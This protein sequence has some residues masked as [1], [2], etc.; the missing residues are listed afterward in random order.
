[1][2]LAALAAFV[3]TIEGLGLFAGIDA[4]FYDHFFR[5]RGSRQ[6]SDRVVVV[7]VDADSLA[8]FGRW[9]LPRHLY[10]ALLDRLEHATVVGFDLL[11]TEPSADDRQLAAASRNHGSVILAGHLERGGGLV[12]PL[13][14]FSPREVA[15]VHVE[16][17]VDHVVRELFHS[18]YRKGVLIPSLSSA[19]YETDRGKPIPRAAFSGDR[20]GLV[21]QDHHRINYYGPAGTFTTVSLVDVLEGRRSPDFF[22]GRLVLVGVTAPGIVDQVA[23]PFS[24]LRTRMPGVELHATALNNLLDAS[25]LR[26]MGQWFETTSLL[27]FS[28]LFARLFLAIRE[29]Q[30]LLAW[31]ASLVM[32]PS[33]SLLLF[34][35]GTWLPPTAFMVS[36][37]VMFAVVYLRRLNRA[38]R[39]LDREYDAMV[40]LLGR[41]IGGEMGEE[42]E[43][44]GLLSMLSEQGINQKIRRQSIMTARLVAMHKKLEAVLET[45]RETLDNQIRFVEMLSHE[46]RT[47]LA[48]I[49]ANLDILELRDEEA[50]KR[51]TAYY[52]KMKRAVSRLTEI[53]DI[54]LSAERMDGTANRMQQR[55]LELTGFVRMLFEESCALWTE[56]T[57]HLELPE[58]DEVVIFADAGLFKT[59]L[60]NLIDNAIKHSPPEEAVSIA[61]QVGTGAAIVSVCNRRPFIPAEELERVFDKYYRGRNSANSQGAGLG[62]YLVRKIVEQQGGTVELSS[63]EEAGTRATVTMPLLRTDGEATAAGRHAS[64]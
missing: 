56:R 62:L 34:V 63:S 54:S 53:M 9:P 40:T 25:A 16:P 32:L 23:T 35:G 12:E 60:L 61:L 55:R 30:A 42:T 45:E 29:Q 26:E 28:L 22:R 48:I 58:G 50:P 44:G 3:S 49:R 27:V 36:G 31:C 15:H 18:I 52:D 6:T 57:L 8:A 20:N 46:Y 59:V 37:S 24:Q 33:A 7:A 5:L 47:P 11:L 21:Q 17:G 4:Y 14:L 43:N 2:L 64:S 39:R 51:F 41:G 10:A 1:M 38:I 19:A 13:P